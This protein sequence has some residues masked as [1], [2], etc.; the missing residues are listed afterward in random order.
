MKKLIW[1]AVIVLSI[2]G[3]VA[4]MQ[5]TGGHN[6]CPPTLRPC[7]P[8]THLNQ[9]CVD[10]ADAKFGPYYESAHF[11]YDAALANL[12]NTLE[13]DQD[14]C[15]EQYDNCVLT[16]GDDCVADLSDCH[17][18]AMNNYNSGLQAAGQTYASITAA[19]D[20]G[21]HAAIA[22]CCVPID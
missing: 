20:A 21:Y 18:Q 1:A 12:N 4:A 16:H 9:S 13:E 11:N 5:Q 14:S 6:P 17:S 22:E 15:N 19:L 7:G 10:A 8:G 3:G 2:I